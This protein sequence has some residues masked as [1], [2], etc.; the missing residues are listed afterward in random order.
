MFQLIFIVYTYC[1]K[2][3]EE[4]NN[5]EFG[6]MYGLIFEFINELKKKYK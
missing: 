3:L 6:K 1:Y 2:L 4:L 5:N